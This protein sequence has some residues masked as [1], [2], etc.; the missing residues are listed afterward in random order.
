MS[1]ATTAI[2]PLGDR[3]IVKADKVAGA[4]GRIERPETVYERSHSGVIVAISADLWPEKRRGLAVGDRIVWSPHGGA[5]LSGGGLSDLFILDIEEVW[6]RIE[7]ETISI[8]IDTMPEE[9][10][11]GAS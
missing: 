8:P 1:D 11:D 4:V 7:Q 2:V 6:G 3:L 5:E 9:S 10:S